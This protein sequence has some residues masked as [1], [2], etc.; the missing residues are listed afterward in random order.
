MWEK[1]K[2]AGAAILGIGFFLVIVLLIGLFI[3][4][5]AWLSAKVY[6][7]LTIAFSITFGIALFILAPLGIFRRTRG[8]SGNGMVIS[9][10]IFGLT[11]W[12]WGFLLTYTLWGGLAVFIGLFLFGVGV[13]PIAMLATLFKG[14]WLTLCQL[15]FLTALTFG[16]RILG[17]FLL[18]R[19]ERI[20]S[21]YEKMRIEDYG[22]TDDDF[23]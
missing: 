22:I 16:S 4:G 8:F 7:W 20:E 21:K 1:I 15:L 5:G 6:P 17:V 13:V 14:M 18:G 19:S 2:G 12:V 11:L 23:E 3:H 9:S 10:Y